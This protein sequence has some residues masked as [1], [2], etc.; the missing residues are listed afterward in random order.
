MNTNMNKA[1]PLPLRSAKSLTEKPAAEL[2]VGR[3]NRSGSRTV[4]MLPVGVS[5]VRNH[6]EMTAYC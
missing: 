4:E 3:G 6:P 5:V 1:W 2:E